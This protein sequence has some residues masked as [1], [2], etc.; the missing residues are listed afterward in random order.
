MASPV[1]HETSD[2][3]VAAVFGFGLGLTISAVVISVIVWGLFVYFSGRAVRRGATGDRRTATQETRLPPEPRLQTNPRGDLGALRDAEDRAL[4]T[5]GWVDRN[6]GV[7][8]IPIEQ[9]LKLTAERGL[10]SRAAKEPAR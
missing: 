5:Y 9:A 3:D 1:H 2:V 10:P 4:T 6:T 8:R 7:V